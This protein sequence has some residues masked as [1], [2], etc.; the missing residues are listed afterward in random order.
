MTLEQRNLSIYNGPKEFHVTLKISPYNSSFSFRKFLTLSWVVEN[1][2]RN[3]LLI[4]KKCAAFCTLQLVQGLC[5]STSLKHFDDH[6]DEENL[7]FFFIFYRMLK[8][9][10]RVQSFPRLAKSNESERSD[11]RFCLAC[12]PPQYGSKRWQKVSR[13]YPSELLFA[14]RYIVRHV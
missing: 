10:M 1:V 14:L 13:C 12:R 2:Q 6:L 7:L 8:N 5:A 9:I 3:L 11:K 4:E